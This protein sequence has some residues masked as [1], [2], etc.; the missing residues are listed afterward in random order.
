MSV[1]IDVKKT[2]KSKEWNI[3]HYSYFL[4]RGFKFQPD[5]Y[6]GCH[7]L[8]MMSRNLSDNPVLNIKGSDCCCI[9]S[10]LTKSEAINIMQNTGFTKK[11]RTL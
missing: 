5:V 4:N 1:G 10:N 11:G 9:I 7:D 6:N 8:L 3:C 2:S